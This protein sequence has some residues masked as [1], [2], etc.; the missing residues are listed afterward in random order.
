MGHSWGSMLHT[1][2][3]VVAVMLLGDWTDG[4]EADG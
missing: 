2:R 3:G 4:S 1:T